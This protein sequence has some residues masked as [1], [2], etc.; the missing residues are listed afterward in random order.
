MTVSSPPLPAEETGSTPKTMVYYL[1]EGVYGS[2]SS[3]LF[4]NTCP[5]PI[6]QVSPQ[7]LP[8]SVL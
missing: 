8:V 6:P 3:V 4:D 7:A 5:S 1:P 2:F